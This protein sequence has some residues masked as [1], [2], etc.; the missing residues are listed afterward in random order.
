MPPCCKA[1]KG[2]SLEHTVNLFF[3]CL[4]TEAERTLKQGGCGRLQKFLNGVV[5]KLSSFR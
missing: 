2:V 4:L 3:Y 5:R 1:V